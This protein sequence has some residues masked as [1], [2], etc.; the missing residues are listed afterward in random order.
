MRVPQVPHRWFAPVLLL[1]VAASACDRSQGAPAKRAPAPG[2]R[3]RAVPVTRQDVVY[4]IK[5]LGSLSADEV[6]Q[7]TAEVEGPVRDVTFNEGQRV[8][9][10]TLLARIDPDKYRLQA[11]RAEA[12]VRKAESEQGRAHAE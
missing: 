7:V 10:Q 1:A 8:T 12:T 3:V 2:L 6:V 11:Q 9:P 4:A 5:A